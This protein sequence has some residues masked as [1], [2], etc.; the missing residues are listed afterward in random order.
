MVHS[1]VNGHLADPSK[2]EA[3]A[4]HLRGHGIAE[5]RTNTVED[6]NIDEYVFYLSVCDYTHKCLPP[7][8]PKEF[9]E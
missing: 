2:L 1:A 6:A 4:D 7:A 3:E 9:K 5:S 8:T